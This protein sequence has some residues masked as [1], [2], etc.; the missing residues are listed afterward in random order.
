MKASDEIIDEAVCCLREKG[1]INYFGLQRF[2]QSVI[3][4][5]H[6]VGKAILKGDWQLVRLITS[7]RSACSFIEQTVL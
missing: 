6:F 4:P 5:T 2:G 3:V 1:F 7:R